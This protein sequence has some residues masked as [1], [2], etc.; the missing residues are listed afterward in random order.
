MIAAAC[1]TVCGLQTRDASG[2]EE[3]KSMEPEY[4]VVY[5]RGDGGGYHTY[6]IP[7]LAVTGKGTI[8]AFCEGRKNSKRDD[9]DI[10]MLLKRSFDNGRTWGPMQLVYEEG[11]G[12]P[13][14][15]GNPCPIVDRDTGTVWL[16]FCRNNKRAFVTHSADDGET[17]AEPVEIAAVAGGPGRNGYGTGPGQGIQLEFGPHKGR[18]LAT[19]WTGML[20]S[21]DHGASWLIGGMARQPAEGLTQADPPYM[22]GGECRVAETVAGDIY[23]TMRNGPAGHRRGIEGGKAAFSW[24][25]DGGATWEAP[26]IKSNI[27]DGDCQHSLVRFTDEKNH[28]RNRHIFANP[29]HLSRRMNLTVRISYDN[30]ATWSDGKVLEPERAAYSDLCV[31]PDMNIGCLYECGRGGRSVY[32]SI[33]FASFSLEWLTDGKD[34]LTDS[35]PARAAQVSSTQ[36]TNQHFLVDDLTDSHAQ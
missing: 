22:Q 20:Y 4:R 28:D 25:R 24:S 9:G 3:E 7:A 12:A 29:D 21:D 18:L 33:M 34:I 5:A 15:I 35:G 6:R 27:I 23:M 10:D 32:D 8:L 11:G 1:L 16:L 30:C 31:L 17:W 36:N 19:A 13:I 14:T 2:G 26:G